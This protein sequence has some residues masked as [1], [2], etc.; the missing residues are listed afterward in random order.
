MKEVAVGKSIALLQGMECG[1]Q[2]PPITAMPRAATYT[3]K[4]K[5]LFKRN[6]DLTS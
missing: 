4:T 6:Y 1:S 5:N 3:V 2:H